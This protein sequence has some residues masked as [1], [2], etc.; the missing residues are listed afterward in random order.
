MRYKF[1]V[2][3]KGTFLTDSMNRIKHTLEGYLEHDDDVQILFCIGS[4]DENP[5]KDDEP[6]FPDPCTW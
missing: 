6:V 1:E 2:V 4:H 3:G 5:I